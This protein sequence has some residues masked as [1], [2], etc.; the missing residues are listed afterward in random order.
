MPRLVALGRKQWN[1]G[2]YTSSDL[3]IPTGLTRASVE[4]ERN[5]WDTLPGS[6]P[7]SEVIRVKLFMSFDAGNNWQFMA[8]AAAEGGDLVHWET[9]DPITHSSFSF[10]LPEP[11]N[12][13]NQIT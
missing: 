3:P 4:F 10:N 12:P 6:P 13:V 11:D 8:G 9:G 2:T 7:D 1:V 5:S